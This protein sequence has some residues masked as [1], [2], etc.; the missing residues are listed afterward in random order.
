MCIGQPQGTCG[1]VAGQ[2]LSYVLRGDV[3]Q[4]E[5]N[6]QNNLEFNPAVD[7]QPVQTAENQRYVF[8]AGCEG[9]CVKSG[10]FSEWSCL[11]AKFLLRI[12]T[13]T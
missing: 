11:F 5:V 6:E 8:S 3:V 10:S 13:Q 9:D 2:H 4:A 1:S 12:A 7:R